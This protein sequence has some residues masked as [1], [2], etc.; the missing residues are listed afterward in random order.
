MADQT[1]AEVLDRLSESENRELLHRKVDCI[2]QG[3]EYLW[4]ARNKTDSGEPQLQVPYYPQ[5]NVIIYHVPNAPGHP[6]FYADSDYVA[7]GWEHWPIV[8][9]PPQG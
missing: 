9:P 7:E 8:P 5:P 6:R 4:N 3:I 1:Y 2:M